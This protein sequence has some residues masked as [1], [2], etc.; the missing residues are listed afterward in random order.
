MQ[1]Y[2]AAW[3]GHFVLT[4]GVIVK[5]FRHPRVDVAYF[6]IIL[7]AALCQQYLVAV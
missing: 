6:Q 3:T 7:G 4:N 1:S 2:T 5:I